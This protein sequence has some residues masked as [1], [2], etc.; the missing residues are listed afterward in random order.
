LREQ[1]KY[2]GETAKK[3]EK[4]TIEEWRFVGGT[5]KGRRDKKKLGSF[6]V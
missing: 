5:S 6:H 2:G 4:G 1:R 3:K